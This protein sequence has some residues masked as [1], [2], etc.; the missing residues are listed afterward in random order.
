MISS[1]LAQWRLQYQVSPIYLTGGIA[2]MAGGTVALT[3]YTNAGTFPNVTSS[4][5][6]FD[7]D[8]FFAYFEPVPGGT[9][10]ANEVGKYPFANQTTA[11]NAIVTQPLAISMMMI[12]P[13]KNPGDFTL[14]PAIIT[15]LKRTLDQHIG[16]GGTFLVATPSFVY[17]D[18]LMTSFRDASSGESRQPQFRWQLDFFK[19]LITLADAQ[20]AQNS[21][22]NKLSSGTQVMPDNSGSISWS[23]PSNAV[24]DPSSGAAPT[25]VPATR[26]SPAVGYNGVGAS[27][28]NLVSPFAGAG[29]E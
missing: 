15:N 14:K 22:M 21:L 2:G 16:A 25:V 19:P 4:G 27:A 18:V 20:N 28:F 10:I 26:S 8:D 5:L 6:D 29:A 23:N 24:A 9:L 17:T 3:N 12:C 11:A 13:A 7:L 1:G